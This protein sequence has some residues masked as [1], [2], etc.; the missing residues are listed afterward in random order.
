[1]S[2]QKLTNERLAGQTPILGPSPVRWKDAFL[3]RLS[4]LKSPHLMG[5]GFRGGVLNQGLLDAA[6]ISLLNAQSV[7]SDTV[8]LI[9]DS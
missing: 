3:D 6:S 9:A 1:M 8:S 5:R 2:T 7:F 4:P